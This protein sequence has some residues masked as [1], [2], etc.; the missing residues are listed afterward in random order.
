VFLSGGRVV[1]DAPVPE[2]FRR[3]SEMGHDAYVLPGSRQPSALSL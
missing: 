1:V 2:A 3:L